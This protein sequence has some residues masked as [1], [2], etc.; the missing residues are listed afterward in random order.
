MYWGMR[1]KAKDIDDVNPICCK[2]I[3]SGYEAN[4]DTDPFAISR[5]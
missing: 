4:Q 2:G 1:D 5:V 3:L